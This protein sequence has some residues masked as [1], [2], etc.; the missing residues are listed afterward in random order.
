MEIQREDRGLFVE[1]DG[2]RVAVLTWLTVGD[3]RVVDHTWVH[4][5]LRGRGI[6]EK[7]M[8]EADELAHREDHR[9]EAT[10]SYAVT[11]LAAQRR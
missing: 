5:R 9:L 6:A 11:W 3:A 7:L 2:Q 1:E 8:R 10:C 4:P